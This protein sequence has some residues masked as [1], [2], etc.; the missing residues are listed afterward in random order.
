MMIRTENGKPFGEIRRAF[1]FPVLKFLQVESRFCLGELPGVL[2]TVLLIIVLRIFFVSDIMAE[3]CPV[4]LNFPEQQKIFKRLFRPVIDFYQTALVAVAGLV[5]DGL[6]K[7]SGRR[8]E[9]RGPVQENS[10]G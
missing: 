9:Y 3:F 10:S 7:G 4:I 8:S 2:L 6:N 1:F 5:A